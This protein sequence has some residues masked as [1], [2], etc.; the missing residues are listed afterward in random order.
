MNAAKRAR[1]EQ[2]RRFDPARVVDQP[3]RDACLAVEQGRRVSKGRDPE[4]VVEAAGYL[5]ALQSCH[6]DRDRG[7]VAWHW[8]DL[9][10]ARLLAEAGGPP[11]WEVQSWLLA[12]QGDEQVAGLCGLPARVVAAYEAL[13]FYVRPRLSARDWILNRA[14]WAGHTLSLTMPD[15]GVVLRSIGYFSG[16]L[17]LEVVLAATLGRPLPA[18]VA[19]GAPAGDTTYGERL[20]LRARLLADALMLPADTGLPDLVRLHQ[21]LHELRADRPAPPATATVAERA[22]RLVE[23][24]ELRRPNPVC[25]QSA[26]AAR[27]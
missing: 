14:I 6:E 11:A 2:L 19:Q 22:R 27:A 26:A 7:R 5:R 21:V 8:S 4:P 10:L 13:F 3:W 25:D 24:A 15:L 1:I 17:V 18:W 16:P 9:H 12:G 20:L 23:G